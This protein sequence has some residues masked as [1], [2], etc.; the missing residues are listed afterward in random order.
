MTSDRQSPAAAAPSAAP[1]HFAISCGGTGGHFYP[2]LATAAELRRRGHRVTLWLTGRPSERAAEAAWD[3]PVVRIPAPI[4][5]RTPLGLLRALVA[6]RRATALARAEMRRDRPS[7]LLAMGSYTS[8][9]PA[10]AALAER[11]PLVFHEGN[12]IPGDVIRWF[13]PRAAAVAA[14]F[15]EAAPHLRRARR[16]VP[17]GMPLRQDLLDAAASLPPRSSLVTRHSSLHVLVVG[18]S[19]GA[20][21]LNLL[22]A[23]A[24]IA[25]AATH[26]LRVTHLAGAADAPA[27]R[28]RYAAAALPADVR[29]YCSDMAPLYASADLAIARAGGSTCAELALFGLPAYLVPFPHAAADH[30]SANAAALFSRGAA[31]WSRESALTPAA[32]A[33]ALESMLPTLPAMSSSALSSALPDASTRLSSLLESLATP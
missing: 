7:A 12:V 13:A 27:I 22:A 31:L 24:L 18:G 25:L 32:L 21:A 6:F 5:T 26:P 8:I 9:G 17:V 10:R 2:G 29:D 20:H 11:V 30:Q 1:L 19:L 28:D 33:T 4:P 23:D 14:A 16:F 15:P 3:G